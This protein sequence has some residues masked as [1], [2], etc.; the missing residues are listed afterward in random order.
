VDISRLSIFHPFFAGVLGSWLALALW[1][2]QDETRSFREVL[3]TY[4]SPG[5]A[6]PLMSMLLKLGSTSRGGVSC[7]HI[8][9][10]IYN[11]KLSYI[12]Y[13]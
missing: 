2:Q 11:I 8:H 12:I 1:A 4:S 10:Y 7:I 5:G 6:G 9:I 3:V 13:I